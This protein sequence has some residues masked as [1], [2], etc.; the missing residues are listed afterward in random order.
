MPETKI[1]L[2]R[3]AADQPAAHEAEENPQKPNP[4]RIDLTPP[5]PLNFGY[6]GGVRM[7]KTNA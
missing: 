2:T 1:A 7:P 4:R 6:I 5:E 3:P